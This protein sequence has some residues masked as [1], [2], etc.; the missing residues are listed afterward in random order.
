M[1]C[2]FLGDTFLYFWSFQKKGVITRASLDLGPEYRFYPIHASLH[3]QVCGGRFTVLC[4]WLGMPFLQRRGDL[5]LRYLEWP[6]LLACLGVS[7]DVRLLV[8]KSGQS[9]TNQGSWS[10]DSIFSRW[11]DILSLTQS[12]Q[13]NVLASVHQWSSPSVQME[14]RYFSLSLSWSHSIGERPVWNLQI[15][16]CH[17]PLMKR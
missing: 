12:G 1:T 15:T 7:W 16:S 14:D 6:T 8:L 13:R 17:I 9:R 4:E 5:C 2:S 11:L 10:P 3:L